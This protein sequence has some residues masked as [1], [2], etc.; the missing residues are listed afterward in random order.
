MLELMQVNTLLNAKL[1]TLPNRPLSYIWYTYIPERHE[2]LA[3]VAESSGTWFCSVTLMSSKVSKEY[4]AAIFKVGEYTLPTLQMQA[5][6]ELEHCGHYFTWKERECDGIEVFFGAVT[7]LLRDSWHIHLEANL[8]LKH[9][10]CCWA[11]LVF[12]S[13]GHGTWH[14]VAQFCYLQSNRF[15]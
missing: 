14:T 6:K 1:N 9:S 12:H 13:E 8:S 2:V 15:T 5:L 3:V 10:W 4:N 7:S 11:P